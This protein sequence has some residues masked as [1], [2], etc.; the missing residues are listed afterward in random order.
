MLEQGSLQ[1]M[2]KIASFLLHIICNFSLML[3]HEKLFCVENVKSK[4]ISYVK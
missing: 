3:D 2:W 1:I 4:S